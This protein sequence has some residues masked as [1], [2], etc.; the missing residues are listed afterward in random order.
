MA[1]KGLNAFNCTITGLAPMLMHNERLANPLSDETLR[2]KALTSK[3]KKTDE[4]VVLISRAEFD[5]G[6]YIDETGPYIPAHW[7]LAMIRDGGKQFKLGKA[8]TQGVIFRQQEF[9][10]T[11]PKFNGASTITADDLWNAGCYDRRMVGNQKARVLRTRPRFDEWSV[12]VSFVFDES[13]FD[14]RQLQQIL[15][16]AGM[17]V[18]LGDYRPLFGRFEVKV[19]A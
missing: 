6:L 14:R 17:K 16:V 5:G 18:G 12:D 13:V 2:L 9:P 8:V 15:E 10:L 7:L 11:L 4:D 3:R 1:I 19:A